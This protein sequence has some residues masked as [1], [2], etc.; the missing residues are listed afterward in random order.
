MVEFNSEYDIEYRI[1]W[2]NSLDDEGMHSA[3]FTFKEPAVKYFQTI[4]KKYPNAS[5][6]TTIMDVSGKVFQTKTFNHAIAEEYDRWN[7]R[8]VHLVKYAIEWKR[9]D[10]Y[11]IFEDFTFEEAN[12]IIMN[13][14][15]T[16]GYGTKWIYILKPC[17]MQE[18]IRAFV[19]PLPK[20]ITMT[21][22]YK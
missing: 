15:G 2:C 14:I 19:P 21:V 13:S 4:R 1:D 10:P 18:H 16:E 20:S 9:E 6:V 7:G 12:Q 11:Y 17:L 3:K 8:R 5:I 22:E